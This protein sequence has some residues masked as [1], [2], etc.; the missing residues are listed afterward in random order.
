MFVVHCPRCAGFAIPD[1]KV[2]ADGDVTVDSS[3][4][5][6]GSYGSA[7]P[8]QYRGR[9]CV[10]KVRRAS[11]PCVCVPLSPPPPAGGLHS[12]PSAC[13][14]VC[15]CCSPC[16]YPLPPM[17]PFLRIHMLRC[18]RLLFTVPTALPS[19]LRYSIGGG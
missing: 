17:E 11:S 10:V 5:W 1:G 13:R 18:L 2:V 9:A 4:T 7:H 8:A 14:G 19:A 12:H 16:L 3:V 15:V 6:K